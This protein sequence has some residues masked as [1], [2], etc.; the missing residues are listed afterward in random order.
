MGI[1]THHHPQHIQQA[2]LADGNAEGLVQPETLLSK[3]PE[4]Q[5]RSDKDEGKQDLLG[6]ADREPFQDRPGPLLQPVCS[7]ALQANPLS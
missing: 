3:L 7:K 5:N 4:A 6:T 1:R 2:V